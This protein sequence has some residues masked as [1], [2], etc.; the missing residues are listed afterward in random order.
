MLKDYKWEYYTY[1]FIP[2]H[3]V[4]AQS[5]YSVLNIPLKS[6]CFRGGAIGY[7]MFFCVFSLH[8][9]WVCGA[10]LLLCF[11]FLKHATLFRSD[12]LDVS[13]RHW[14][15]PISFGDYSFLFLCPLWLFFYL[16]VFLNSLND[17][18]SGTPR[19]P[20]APKKREFL[21]AC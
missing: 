6:T 12:C 2:P 21:Q 13:N 15:K 20:F 1:F 4:F 7:Q 10:L 11:S 16:Y 18:T 3:F 19:L 9:P 14:I 5:M 8:V 17:C